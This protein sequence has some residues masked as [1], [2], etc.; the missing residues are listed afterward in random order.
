MDRDIPTQV[1]VR[2]DPSDGYGHRYDVI[3]QAK[4]TFDVGNNTE[5]IVK[6]CDLA[7][8]VLPQIEDA[9]E[10][11]DIRPSEKEKLAEKLSTRQISVEVDTGRVDLKNE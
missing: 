4:A 7:G 1:R 2:T 10:E 6:A 8:N 3:Q 11:A 9:L 5:A